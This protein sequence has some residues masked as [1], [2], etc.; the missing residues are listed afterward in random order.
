MQQFRALV[1]VVQDDIHVRD[2]S[3]SYG[4]RGRV[5][6]RADLDS[7]PPLPPL[8]DLELS[9]NELSR[10]FLD[11]LWQEQLGLEPG[12]FSGKFA[13][14]AP[15]TENWR[16]MMPDASGSLVGTGRD[17]SFGRIGLVTKLLTV[18]RTTAPL[19]MRLPPF[20]DE[21]L[22]YDEVR[23]DITMESGRMEVRSFEL[24]SISYAISGAGTVDFRELTTRIPIEL[25]AIRGLTMLVERVPVAG[26]A[27]KIVNVRLI[28]TG[29]PWDMDLSVASIQDHLIG[30]GMAGPRAVINGVRDAL[31]LLRRA[32]PSATPEPAGPETPPAAPPEEAP[33]QETPAPEP[34]AP[35]PAPPSPTPEPAPASELRG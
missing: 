21:G 7:R 16:D 6:G 23:F 1:E 33:L 15:L 31:E 34:P 28:A 17:G 9:F 27:L 25:N 18:L 29:S 26:D 30:A 14:R 3:F 32:A 8:L 35:E 24:D 19:R 11:E 20:S 10:R 2:L 5:S 22:V 4:E 13:L 12:I